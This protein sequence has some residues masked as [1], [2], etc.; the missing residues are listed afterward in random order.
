LSYKLI[1]TKYTFIHDEII[2]EA[3]E[4]I[5]AYVTGTGKYCIEHSFAGIIPEVT[6]VVKPEIRDSWR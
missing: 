3:K 1:V 2:I 4:E 5:A 6:F